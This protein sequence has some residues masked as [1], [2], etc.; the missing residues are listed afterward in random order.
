MLQQR[1]PRVRLRRALANMTKLETAQI[2]KEKKTNDP[3]SVSS[4]HLSHRVSCLKDFTNLERLDLSCNNLSTLEVTAFLPDPTDAS[5]SFLQLAILP[6]VTTIAVSAIGL[7]SCIN[8]KWL[9]VVQN[10]L[11]SLKG[12]EDLS[13]LTVLNAGRNKLSSMDEVRSLTN[14]RA[15]ILNA[16]GSSLVDC[17]DLKEVRLAHNEIMF[18]SMTLPSELSCNVKIQN[19]DIGDNVIQKWSDL[20]IRKLLPNLQIFNGKPIE[21]SDADD[22]ISKNDSSSSKKDFIHMDAADIK[23]GKEEERGKRKTDKGPK[24]DALVQLE[25][26]DDSPTNAAKNDEEKE[27]EKHA[28]IKKHKKLKESEVEVIDDG[29][30]PFTEIIS[31]SIE[32]ATD[33]SSRKRDHDSIKNR[34]L[35]TGVVSIS[36]KKKKVGKGVGIGHPALELFSSASEVGMGG[37]SAWGET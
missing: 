14:L 7:R 31:M 15:L 22:K 4:L 19:L 34:K 5:D 29:E 26:N 23:S 10:K 6:T 30:M 28:K 13:K 21:R 16:L 17:I 25:D 33:S 11:Q 36:S 2:S 9:S 1:L 27:A 18:S 8:L 32:G 37:P 3:A 24:K 20:K 35:L 12:T